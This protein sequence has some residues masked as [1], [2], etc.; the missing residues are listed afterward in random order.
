MGRDRTSSRREDPAPAARPAGLLGLQAAV[1]N[2]A[3]VQ[4][5]RRAGGAEVQRSAVHDVLRTGGRPLDEGVR[6]DM[7]ARLGADFSDVRVHSDARARASA[8][9][10][11]ARAYTSGNHIV[12]GDGGGDRHTLAHELT[13]VIQQRRGPVA[14][15]ETGDGLRVSDPSDRFERE[16]EATAHRVLRGSPAGAAAHGPADASGA[17]PAGRP[18][19][20]RLLVLGQKGEA[21]A[22]E[23]AYAEIRAELTDPELIS[24]WEDTKNKPAIMKVLDEWITAPKQSTPQATA[25]S[26]RGPRDALARSYATM[27][28]AA[29][30]VLDRVNALPVADVEKAISDDV[31]V[32][33]K[34]KEV[35][36]QFV[37][38]A[39]RP[40]L[41][42]QRKQVTELEDVLSKTVA[43]LASVR[44]LY[45]P[46]IEFG[47]KT[48]DGIL[49]NP[50]AQGFATLISAIHDIAEILYGIKELEQHVTVSAEQFKGYVLKDG[51]KLA[52]PRNS[53]SWALGDGSGGSVDDLERT[54]VPNTFRGAMATPNQLNDQVRTAGHLGYPVSLGPSRTTGKLM[55]LADT[56]GAD[57]AVKEAIAYSLLALWYTDYRRDL[58]DIHRYHFV[59]DMAANFGVAYDPYKA[60]RNPATGQDYSQLIADTLDRFRKNHEE[61]SAR[62]WKKA[63]ELKLDPPAVPG[64]VNGP[65]AAGEQSA[66]AV[67]EAAPAWKTDPVARAVMAALKAA[68]K[69][70]IPGEKQDAVGRLQ[71][72]EEQFDAAFTLLTSKDHVGNKPL[73][74]IDRMGLVLTNPGK[75]AAKKATDL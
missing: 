74:Q 20:Q 71:L 28:E 66:Q 64:P 9:A 65:S 73:V 43:E 39:L 13:H 47:E 1:G 57:P 58:T 32:D 48:L 69:F 53:P 24:A 36:A 45:L 12:I 11:G 16:A 6:T 30:A 61:E 42:E 2:A 25:K 49:G 37:A 4:M 62:Y 51:A 59:M 22:A 10:M 17:T 68:P 33:A 29:S 67:A 27:D 40:W 55:K 44:R 50:E 54:P 63:E 56:T 31:A 15:T 34:I 75:T 8:T 35:L 7:E 21:K 70:R 60:P 41:G 23:P 38:N 26:K 46:Y 52:G 18:S 5:L 19:V 3:V 14:G 72:T